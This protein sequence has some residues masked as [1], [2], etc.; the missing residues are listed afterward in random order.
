ME[1]EQLQVGDLVEN[2]L[3]PGGILRYGGREGD[4][5]IVTEPNNLEVRYSTGLPPRRY[6]ALHQPESGPSVTPIKGSGVTVKQGG[7]S[8]IIINKQWVTRPTDRPFLDLAS[9]QAFKEGVRQSSEQPVVSIRSIQL[10]YTDKVNGEVYAALPEQFGV[11]APGELNQNRYGLL[12]NWS[13]GQ[14]AQKAGAPAGYLRK[15][16][17]ALAVSNLSWGLLHPPESV[18]EDTRLLFSPLEEATPSGITHSVAAVTSSTYGRI[19]DVDVVKRVGE[20]VERTGTSWRVPGV[21]PGLLPTKS[22]TTLYASD[23]DCFIALVDEDH[24]VEVPGMADRPKYRG[25]VVWNSEVGSQRFGLMPF[26][27]DYICGNRLIWGMTNASTL[28]IRHTSGGPDKFAR[29]AVP[30]LVAYANEGTGD[31]VAS[32]Q[33]ARATRL[34]GKEG[35]VLAA[36]EGLGFA[37]RTGEIGMSLAA[38]YTDGDVRS[39]WNLIEG[40]TEYSASM[41]YQDERRDLE[42][43]IG[44]GLMAPAAAR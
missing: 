9:L 19:W 27:F 8:G 10:G 2:P 43:A 40:L 33:A 28:F 13:F 16:P 14:M 6:A 22:S 4:R 23:R 17:A 24:P 18:D 37:K 38:K 36:L 21:R 26:L 3:K 7:D 35:E 15:L 42:V 25:F 31:L 30:A 41:P 34:A 39:N 20:L 5:Y 1:E 12:T 44:K 32:I 29:E 11:G